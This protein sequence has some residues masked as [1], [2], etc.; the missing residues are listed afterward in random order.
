MDV[1]IGDI[2]WFAVYYPATHKTDIR[3]VVI[4]D[5]VDGQ[6]VVA[7][8]AEIT[9]SPI[10]NFNDRYDKWQVPIFCWSSA[11]LSKP[12]YA[13]VNCI[14]TVFAKDFKPGNYIG[15]IHPRDL[16]NIRKGIEDFINSGENPW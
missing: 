12:S 1:Q 15:K 7:T 9:S 6:P 16:Y 8:F 2:Y 3:P 10:K 5:I 14:A 13:K 11:G 4:I